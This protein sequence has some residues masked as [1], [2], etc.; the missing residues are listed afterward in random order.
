M[1][2]PQFVATSVFNQSYNCSAVGW[3]RKLHLFLFP[4]ESRKAAFQELLILSMFILRTTTDSF[5]G[6]PTTKKNNLNDSF[7]YVNI[8]HQLPWSLYMYAQ[9]VGRQ[10]ENV[11]REPRSHL[12]KREPHITSFSLFFSDWNIPN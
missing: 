9:L 8:K 4:L 5:G 1:V 2:I 10:W 7:I 12:S 6:S 11:Q 3:Q